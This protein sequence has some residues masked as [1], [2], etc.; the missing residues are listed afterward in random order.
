M[1]GFVIQRGASFTKNE[2]LIFV[3]G[4][5]VFAL[6]NG[7]PLY[8]AQASLRS[9]HDKLSFGSQVMFTATPREGVILVH[10]VFD[11]AI[12]LLVSK[13][14]FVKPNKAN[15]TDALTSRG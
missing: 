5:V 13:W 14:P 4:F 10:V 11:L 1:I 3:I 8:Q 6:S 12:V 2:K 7:V 9:I 15:P